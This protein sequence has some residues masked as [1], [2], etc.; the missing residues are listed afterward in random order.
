MIGPGKAI[1]TGK[2]FVICSNVLGGCMG[3]TG[4]AP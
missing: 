4:R 2:Y 1:D 3:S